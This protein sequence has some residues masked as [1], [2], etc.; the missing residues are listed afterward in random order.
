MA[1]PGLNPVQAAKFHMADML[2]WSRL[3]SGVDSPRHTPHPASRPIDYRVRVI[4]SQN[5]ADL[6]FDQS[7]P[8]HVNA[9]ADQLR[10][11]AEHQL[12]NDQGRSAEVFDSMGNVRPEL[13]AGSVGVA[14]VVGSG[15]PSP[16]SS[17]QGSDEGESFAFGNDGSD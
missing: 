17:V 12:I 16:E 13:L 3:L 10:T 15:E 5:G 4:C 6:P 7:D 14:V 11:L 2:Q 8:D 9:I 1:N